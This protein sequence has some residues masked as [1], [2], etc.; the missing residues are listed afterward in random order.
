MFPAH[1]LCPQTCQ[2]QG[3]SKVVFFESD[4]VHD[5]C[6][7]RHAISA[8]ARDKQRKPS[9]TKGALLCRLPSCLKQV[10]R[11]PATSEVIESSNNNINN[12]GC[13]KGKR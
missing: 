3:C 13:V 10:Y 12:V 9:G 11:D 7:R 5:Y 8:K 1:A 4:T 2:L 6:C